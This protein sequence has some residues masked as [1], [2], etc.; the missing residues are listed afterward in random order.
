M[1]L[2]N[3]ISTE[4]TADQSE[5]IS[6]AFEQLKTA[7]APVLVINLTA[8]ER[9]SMLKMGD[10]TLAF[11]NKTLEYA[12]Q[13]PAL[14]P[15]YINLAEARKDN[16]LSSDIYGIFQQ[17]STL[18]RAMEDTGMVAGAEAY[19]AALVIYHSIKG[20]SRSNIPGIQAICDDLK[21]RFP[22]RGKHNTTPEQ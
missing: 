15:N 5:A 2:S 17:L 20:A 19:E 21:Q 14:V 1:S 22:G 12:T 10:K 11:V 18:L 4:I 8:A 7:L 6:A 3:R 16:K 13:N 9:K